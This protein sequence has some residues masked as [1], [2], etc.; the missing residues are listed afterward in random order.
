M[1]KIW[2]KGHIEEKGVVAKTDGGGGGADR[3][4]GRWFRL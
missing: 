4:E 1:E 2:D 3:K